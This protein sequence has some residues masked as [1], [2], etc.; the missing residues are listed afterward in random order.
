MNV[1]SPSQQERD[2]LL[3]TTLGNIQLVD[4]L[5]KGGMGTVYKGEHT[6]LK[7]PYAVKIL[8][9]KFSNNDEM[10][11]RFRREAMACSALRHP[12]IVFVTDFGFHRD[13]GL[14]LVMEFLTGQ[15]LMDL[16][17]QVQE[18]RIPLWRVVHIGE[19]MC[20]AFEAAHQAGIVH[21][22]LKP[23]NIWLV[24]R[25]SGKDLVKVLDF[26]I[27]RLNQPLNDDGEE[28][29]DITRQNHVMGTPHYISPE[30][31]HGSSKAT[32][33]SDI[34]SLGVLVYE[35]I[36]GKTPFDSKSLME[37]LTKHVRDTA[38]L[39]STH[40]PELA[41]TKLEALLAQTLS[42]RPEDRPATMG[43]VGT[44]LSEALKELQERGIWDATPQAVSP[45]MSIQV[46][47]PRMFARTGQ[48]R[49]TGLLEELQDDNHVTRF[50]KLY[51]AL[52]T[53]NTLPVEQ[54][55]VASW[56]A[57][58]RDLLDAEPTS[59]AFKFSLTHFTTLLEGLLTT[60]ESVEEIQEAQHLIQHSIQ[61]MMTLA[62]KEKREALLGSFK[63]LTN[64]YLFPHYV[65]SDLSE[66]D[67]GGGSWRA[68]KDVL[69]TDVRDFFKKD[70]NAKSTSTTKEP[71]PPPT[72]D[73]GLMDKLKQD[74][75]LG[76]IRSVLTHE[77]RLFKKKKAD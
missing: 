57:I 54:F 3:G 74:V 16:M 40:R 5:G 76:S 34:Y 18:G 26:G 68:L 19:Q 24:P 29:N 59:E 28:Y 13:A 46:Q 6:T 42:K 2:A 51:R 73:G 37:L 62:G 14:Y 66:T 49:L 30:Q 35:M 67:T 75:S 41:N 8:L 17:E 1:P 71:T 39:L 43:Q 9:E 69:T 44:R 20:D 7:T 22:D 21:R 23:E 58:Q 47:S 50:A 10:L 27:A 63:H 65:L 36:A 60:A 64:H 56:G 53:L 33:R 70:E 77:I 31:I 38:P 12:N 11:E 61:E 45:D 72:Q 55:F 15:T 32:S 4:I 48:F 52:P 25:S